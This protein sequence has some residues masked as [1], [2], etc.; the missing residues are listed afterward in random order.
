MNIAKSGLAMGVARLL[1]FG[2][3][4]GAW[5]FLSA[6]HTIDTVLFGRPSETLSYLYRELFI[7][8]SLIVDLRWTLSAVFLAFIL[9]SAAGIVVGLFFATYPF[10]ER[11]L[12]PLMTALN[13][14][15]RIALAPLFIIWFGL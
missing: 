1:L 11:L 5:E 12:D 2:V 15:P 9:G 6:T 3:L 7:T 10:F 14:M 13:A 8:G 4:F